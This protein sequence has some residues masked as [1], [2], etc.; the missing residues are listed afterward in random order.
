MLKFEQLVELLTG[1]ISMSVINIYYGYWKY[2]DVFSKLSC[3]R[4][5]ESRKFEQLVELL[6]DDGNRVIGIKF[7]YKTPVIFLCICMPCRGNGHT[8]DDYQQ[9]LDEIS[10][11]LTKYGGTSLLYEICD[12]G[13]MSASFRRASTKDKQFKQFAKDHRLTTGP[14]HYPRKYTINV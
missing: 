1:S 10:E 11:I 9:I 5:C 4:I 6:P 8:A 2:P 14:C 12:R 13:D 7:K 3:S